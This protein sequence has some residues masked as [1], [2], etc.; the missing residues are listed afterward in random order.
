[1][2]Q[3]K[4]AGTIIALADSVALIAIAVYGH[5]QIANIRGLLDDTNKVVT[6]I[7]ISLNSKC[8]TARLNE[9]T[10]IISQ[11][12]KSVNAKNKINLKTTKKVK[13]LEDTVKFIQTAYEKLIAEI[14]A[15]GMNVKVDVMK[16]KK[17][18]VVKK[19]KKGKKGK[20][21]RDD[22]DSD[23][24]DDSDDEDSDSDDE[25]SDDDSDDD[26]RSRRRK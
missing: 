24:S 26:G 20:K 17:K 5:T 10:G 19:G 9:L 4:H 2:D 15:S 25:D 14:K 1:M 12:E 18:K 23:D 21:N 6:A 13:E 16:M 7:N 8:D 22:S 11:L 3:L